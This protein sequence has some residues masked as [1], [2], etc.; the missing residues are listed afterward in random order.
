MQ[1]LPLTVK[2]CMRATLL[3]IREELSRR[4]HDLIR[5]Q[6][7]WLKRVISGYFNYHAVPEN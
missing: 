3:A 1:V 2:K 6:G 7:R 4:R 5:I